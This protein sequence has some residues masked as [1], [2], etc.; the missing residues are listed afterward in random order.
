[1]AL[2]GAKGKTESFNIAHR[3][4]FV[5][6]FDQALRACEEGVLSRIDGSCSVN[7]AFNY[8]R[9]GRPHISVRRGAIRWSTDP[10]LSTAP[11]LNP[12]YPKGW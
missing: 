8:K 4:F 10:Q 9:P 12:P 2:S 6:P 7:A 1:M 5:W 3:A 11:T